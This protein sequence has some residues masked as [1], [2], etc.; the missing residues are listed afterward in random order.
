MSR[1]GREIDI[2]ALRVSH[3]QFNFY[4]FYLDTHTEEHLELSYLYP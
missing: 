1:L 3:I 2:E 4:V